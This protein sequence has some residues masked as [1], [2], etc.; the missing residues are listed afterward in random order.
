MK[1]KQ[2]PIPYETINTPYVYFFSNLFSIK[3]KRNI[4]NTNRSYTTFAT[5][6][7]CI[8][9]VVKQTAVALTVTFGQFPRIAGP[10]TEARRAL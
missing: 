10:Y 2:A 4:P 8:A 7:M 1:K 3:K 6:I 5:R 9:I